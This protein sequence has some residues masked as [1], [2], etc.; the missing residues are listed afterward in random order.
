MTDWKRKWGLSLQHDINMRSQLVT[1][2]WRVG[3]GGGEMRVSVKQLQVS[4]W[5]FAL[6]AASLTHQPVWVHAWDAADGDHLQGR[7]AWM[8]DTVF[9]VLSYQ[10]SFCI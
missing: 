2:G 4:D 6:L 9:I 7:G 1:E 10:V 3:G 5:H 8:T